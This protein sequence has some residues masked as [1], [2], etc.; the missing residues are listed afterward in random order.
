ML[1]LL[2]RI[3]FPIHTIELGLLINV[4]MKVIGIYDMISITK[5]IHA[6]NIEHLA[7]VELLGLRILC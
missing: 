1:L 6:L 5:L 2:Y 7:N 4:R 3:Y